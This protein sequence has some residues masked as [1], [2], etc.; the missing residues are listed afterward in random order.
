MHANIILDHIDT[1]LAYKLSV[2]FTYVISDNL[3]QA[4]FDKC[5]PFI[6]LIGERSV[7]D[8]LCA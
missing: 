5:R 6:N 1:A 2:Q 4:K 3:P 7:E 8:D